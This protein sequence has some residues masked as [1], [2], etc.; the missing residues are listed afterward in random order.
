MRACK[1][2]KIAGVCVGFA[3]RLL[4]PPSDALGNAE[5]DGNGKAIDSKTCSSTRP[6][7]TVFDC[8]VKV[9]LQG[10]S[11]LLE[12]SNTGSHKPA[13]TM[14]R[15]TIVGNSRKSDRGTILVA[16]LLFFSVF[17]TNLYKN[18][19]IFV[20]APN[21]GVTADL[22]RLENVL[23][24]ANTTATATSSS[25][26]ERPQPYTEPRGDTLS[27]EASRRSTCQFA[28]V[29]NVSTLQQSTSRNCKN[30]STNTGLS[31]CILSRGRSPV[32]Y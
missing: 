19:C 1:P 18:S 4:P 26:P 21:E 14:Q 9:G 16:A 22:L 25:T 6:E 7:S 32:R 11:S 29:G 15:R 17:L 24:R 31:H 13:T 23:Q 10:L 3:S 5:H 12:A 20:G 2:A 30:G 8:S 28:I 27:R